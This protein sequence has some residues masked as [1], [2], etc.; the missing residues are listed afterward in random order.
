TQERTVHPGQLD[1]GVLRRRPLDQGVDLVPLVDDHGHQAAA[2]FGRRR[3]RLGRGQVALED[4]TGRALA[5]F[6]LEHRGEREAPAGVSRPGEVRPT[7][8]GGPGHPQ[9]PTPSTTTTI[10]PT[11][12]STSR[13]MA[14][15]T[16]PRTWR[17][18][19]TSG[20][21]GRAT[22]ARRASTRRPSTRA[23]SERPP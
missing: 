12:R 16:A 14:A 19:G 8:L 5:E 3:V 21:P 17:V 11:S 7:G 9:E 10:S 18:S 22:M 23:T 1:D 6:G 2:E 20:W 4:R 13:S 15:E